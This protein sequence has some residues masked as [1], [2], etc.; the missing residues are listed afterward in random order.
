MTFWTKTLIT[1]FSNNSQLN[2][3]RPR[4]SRLDFS[5]QISTLSEMIVCCL[6][7]VH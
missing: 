3:I 1:I 6:P 5:N 2:L 7:E 4:T